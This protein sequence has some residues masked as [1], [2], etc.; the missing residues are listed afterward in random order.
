MTPIPLSR[1][2]PA[3]LLVGALLLAALPRI[4]GAQA[5]TASG[6]SLPLHVEVTLTAGALRLTKGEGGGEYFRNRVVTGAG[7]TVARAVGSP[8]ERGDMRPEDDVYFLVFGRAPDGEPFARVVAP[9]SGWFWRVYPVGRGDDG[10]GDEIDESPLWEADLPEGASME[11]G[12]AVLEYD[13][14]GAG[15]SFVVNDAVAADV[16]GRLEAV[17]RVGLALAERVAR[18]DSLARRPGVVREALASALGPRVDDVI[19][20]MAVE[21]RAVGGRP[22]ATWRPLDDAKDKGHSRFLRGRPL[23]PRWFQLGGDGARYE[24]HLRVSAR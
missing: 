18:G 21:V 15:G 6:A 5:S 16:V 10:D 22:Q 8:R 13:G 7:N 4:S 20:A 1:R 17:Q 3:A 23:K 9:S 12:I 14:D 11:V 24:A 19:G 2:R